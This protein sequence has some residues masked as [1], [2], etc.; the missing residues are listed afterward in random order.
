ETEWIIWRARYDLAKT[1]NAW[2]EEKPEK[3]EDAITAVSALVNEIHERAE[4][5]GNQALTDLL[6]AGWLERGKA[7][8]GNAERLLKLAEEA[9]EKDRKAMARDRTDQAKNGLRWAV[10]RAQEISAQ[11]ET[12]WARNAKMHLDEWIEE[13]EELFDEEIQIRKDINAY[14]SEGW[15]AFEEEKYIKAIDKFQQ[16]IRV[17]DPSVYGSTLIPEAW[18]KM[19]LSY[20]KLSAPEHTENKYNYYHEAALCFNEIVQHHSKAEFAADAGYYAM[21]LYGA[22][23][24]R[25]RKLADGSKRNEA[26]KRFDGRRYY[27]A[28]QKFS[29]EFP[30][31]RRAGETIFQ[32]AEIA[33]EMED[34][35]RAAEIYASI[36]QDHSEFY[37]ARY[38]AG[39]C[40]YLQ[41]LKIFEEN[42]DDIPEEKVADLLQRAG[43]RYEDFIEWYDQNEDWL[44]SEGREM[45]NRWVVRTKVSYGKMLVHRAW[46]ETRD[47]AEGAERA[48]DLLEDVEEEHFT[49][50]QSEDLRDEYLP[51]AYFV[52]IQAHRR[53]EELREAEEFV[54]ALVERYGEHEI[55]ARAAR[56]LGYA[57][58]QRRENLEEEEASE[59]DIELAA[60][61]AGEYLKTALDL[62]PDQTLEFYNDTALQLYD[63]EEYKQAIRILEAGLEQFPLPEDE[64]PGEQHML[65]LT[66]IKDAYRKRE[67]WQEVEN[68]VERLLDIEEKE[69]KR[70]EEE[71]KKPRKNIA[72]R[73]DY[74]LALEEQEKWK[75]AL[76]YWREAKSLAENMEDERGER[77]QFDATTSIARCYAEMGGS[78]TR[79]RGY[80][81]LAWYLLSNDEWLRDREWAE[82]VEE[83]F[84][85]YFSDQFDDLAE[86]TFQLIQGD[87]NLLREDTSREVIVGLV[88]RHWADREEELEELL[89]EAD[90]ELGTTQ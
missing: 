70:R 88:E 28:L 21:Q 31:D 2:G 16:A 42:E 60:Q 76:D 57:Y 14:M 87:I 78:D 82:E 30:K 32:S 89:D 79:D 24:D 90:V 20:Y 51:E 61:S 39:L 12:K 46:G 45:A 43:D 22:I 67:E 48:L 4:V 9:R 17:G 53:L 80:R 55:S 26:D 81:V 5:S 84:E 18:Y 29:E 85:E 63:M 37:E 62:D 25:T 19:G 58:L 49:D 74:A 75:E 71:G 83:I 65:A 7:M 38:R 35:D 69:N 47:E 13:G 73:R 68:T 56:Y 44:D 1:Y 36:N 11:G 54:D 86:Y 72:Y 6:F 3:Y 77:I 41:G 50:D 64:L 66:G 34:Y 15:R 23:F 59:T 33:R 52:V 10:E 27:E 40:R 8:V